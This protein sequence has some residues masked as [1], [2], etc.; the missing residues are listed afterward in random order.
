MTT[1]DPTAIP[2]IERTAILAHK[3]GQ[4][5]LARVEEGLEELGL[6]SRSYFVLSAVDCETPRSQQEM[7]QLLTIDPTAIGV[8]VDDLEARGLVKRARNRHDRRRYD[9]TLSEAGTSALAAAHEALATAEREF[10][11]PLSGKQRAELHGLLQR[12]IAG[13][14]PPPHE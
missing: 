1:L 14:W 5:L 9:L 12:L 2:L 7:S 11:E 13:R 6:S 10:F 8:V 3:V 4:L